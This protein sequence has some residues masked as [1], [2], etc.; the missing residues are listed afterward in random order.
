ME[1]SPQDGWGPFPSGSVGHGLA[2]LGGGSRTLEAVTL[3]S[4]GAARIRSSRGEKRERDRG[5]KERG[6][7]LGLC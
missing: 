1:K 5:C 2:Q 4:R 7:D 3:R 6:E